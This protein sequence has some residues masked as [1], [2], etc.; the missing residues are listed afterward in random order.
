MGHSLGTKTAYGQGVRNY[1]NFARRFN[2]TGVTFA[3]LQAFVVYLVSDMRL[4]F[5]TIKTYIYAV[6]DW[7]CE[8]GLRDPTI[9]LHGSRHLFKKSLLGAQRACFRRERERRPLKRKHMRNI[10]ENFGKTPFCQRDKLAFIAA[11]LIAYYG[12]LRSG[13]YLTTP[14]NSCGLLRRR[15]IKL[16]REGSSQTINRVK[17]RL[18]CTKTSQLSAK[19]INIFAQ[20]SEW[21]PIKALIAYLNSSSVGMDDPLFWSAGKPFTARRFNMMLRIGA[22]TA[23]LNPV[24]YSSHSLRSGAASEAGD[25]SVPSWVIQRLGRW[26]SNCFSLYIRSPITPLKKGQDAIRV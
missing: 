9:D 11:I 15:D 6:K 18:R 22:K 19:F 13:E 21:C 16:L 8:M 20:E 24:L 1:S 23:G 14:T 7:A 5:K 26:K 3:D 17:I 2:I 25:C 12:F 10:L 4:Q